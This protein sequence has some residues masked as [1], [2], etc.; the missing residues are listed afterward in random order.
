[1]SL[2]VAATIATGI[3]DAGRVTETVAFAALVGAIAWNL[4]TWWL[5]AAVELV[6]RADRRRGRGDAR[7][8]RS[9]RRSTGTGCSTKVVLP[10]LVAPLAAFL[11]RRRRD[12]PS[13][14][15]SVGRRRPGPVT[16]GFRLGQLLSSSALSLA[17]G[18]NDAQK[19]MGVIALALVAHGDLS[20]QHFTFRPGS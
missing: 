4:V 8:R 18:T 2:K 10:A 7:G 3:V 15:G 5:R 14:T 17:H 9:R 16:A 13:S 1:M 20:A 12:R 6:P 19:T 11:R